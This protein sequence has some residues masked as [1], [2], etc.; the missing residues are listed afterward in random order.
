MQIKYFLFLL[1]ALSVGSKSTVAQ[2]SEDTNI[3][4]DMKLQENFLRVGLLYQA[5]GRSLQMEQ[6]KQ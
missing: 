2:N 6:T 5:L 3:N 1:L 4:F